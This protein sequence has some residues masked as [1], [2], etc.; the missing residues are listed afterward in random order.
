MAEI[1][2]KAKVRDYKGR[3]ASNAARRA[4]KVPGV[5]YLGNE[6]NIA[7]EVEALDLRHLIYTSETHIVD[8][9][10]SDGTA[11]AAVLR[12]V[13]FDP[14]TDRVMHFDLIGVIRGQ[15]M[16]FEVPVVLEGSSEGVR[17]GGVLQQTLHKLEVECLPKDLPEYIAVDITHLGAN[18]SMLVGDVKIDGVEILTHGEQ[19]LVVISHIRGEATAEGEEAEEGESEPE[20]IGRGKGEDE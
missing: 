2:L 11:E 4:G 8:L 5:F 3:T 20:V 18:E 17:A 13:Q 9:Q 15:K 1:T 19:P 10:L 12:E 16:K 14:I 6:K 7:I